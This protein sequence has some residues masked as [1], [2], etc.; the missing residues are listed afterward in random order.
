MTL[1]NHHVT[2]LVLLEAVLQSKVKDGIANCLKVTILVLLEA[3]LQWEQLYFLLNG[4]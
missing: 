4:S 3:V 1:L 2:I